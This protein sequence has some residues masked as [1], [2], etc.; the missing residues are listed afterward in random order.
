MQVCK[1]G[2]IDG[3]SHTEPANLPQPASIVSHVKFKVVP[4]CN[5]PKGVLE[6]KNCHLRAS[7]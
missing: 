3:Q 7:K 4:L 1:E 5:T 6:Y 2:F